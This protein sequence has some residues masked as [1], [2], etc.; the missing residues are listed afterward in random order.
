M[1]R[2]SPIV[3]ILAVVVGAACSRSNIAIP[4]I[5]GWTGEPQVAAKIEAARRAVLDDSASADAWG[6]LGMVFQAHDLHS[7][8]IACYDQAARLA[9]EDSRWP[10]LA[11]LSMRTDELDAAVALFE[12]A[13][14]RGADHPAFHVN[15]GDA[16]AQLGESER[17]AQEYRRALE[18]DPAVT[19]ALYGLARLE[20]A[21]G[22]PDQARDYLERAVAIAPWHG[23]ARR[24]LAQTY[25]RLERAEDAARELEAAGAYPEPS[26]AADPIFQ[27]VE[28][29]AVT[30]VAYAS[31]ARRLA[32]EGRFAEAESLYRKVLSIRADVA[33][34]YSNLGGAL[35]G[36]GKLDEAIG[37]YR[38]AIELDDDDPY[39]LNNLAMALAQKSEA[40]QAAGLLL[41]ALAIEPKYPEARHN[42]G[43]VRASQRRFSEAIEHYQEAL[44]QNPSF[45]R[46]H[47]DLGTARAALGEMD[48]AIASWR[49]ALEIDPR[50]LSALHN[51][52][53]ALARAGD[54]RE[55]L[56]WLER[57]VELAPNSSRIVAFLAWELATAPDRDLRDGARA[58]G[59]ARRVHAT[60]PNQPGL[61]D[62]LAAALA[63]SG[64]FEEAVQVADRAVEQARGSGQLA[65]AEQIG[66]RLDGYR[67][68]QAYR[69]DR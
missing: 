39:A 30:A 20:L 6:R 59:L 40:E 37:F 26:Q 9:P 5:D 1:K 58:S 48:E 66:Q 24:L 36:Q 19:H 68:G 33:G 14:R 11:A 60:Y 50:E 27:S 55:A 45:A 65:L 43:L 35:A 44:T 51:L 34:D 69:Q 29:E 7:E 10:Y 54:H 25:Q 22:T 46:A 57:G 67:K 56:E 28:A 18:L 15:L 13:G 3:A 62:V 42:L 52:S 17:S 61:G 49:R 16:L 63:E 41:Q 64:D 8:A 21:D 2:S 23:D 47:N 31:R 12:E 38:K 32:R 53:V 4:A